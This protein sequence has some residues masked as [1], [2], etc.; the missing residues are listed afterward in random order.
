MIAPMTLCDPSELGQRLRALPGAD[1]VLDA[2]A[3]ADG[4]VY[5]VGGTV[6]DLWRGRR[7]LDLDLVV[8]GD[9]SALAE[10]LDDGAGGTRVHDRFGTATLRGPGGVRYDLARA[11]RETYAR[12]GALP[13]VEPAGIRDDLARRDFSVNALALGLSGPQVGRLICAAHGFQDMVGQE[14]RVLHR[15]SF[16]D[17]PIRLLRL[18]RYGA[19]L[20]FAAERGTE[21]LARAAI[22]EGA[23]GT[24]SGARIGAELGLLADE[25][26]PIAG[27][28]ALRA[29]GLDAALHPGFG[30]EDPAAARRALELLGAEGDRGA[31]ALAAAAQTIDP[32]P[33]RA[34]LDDLGFPAARRDAVLGA[35]RGARALAGALSGARGASE[36]AAA[37]GGAPPEAVALAGGLGAAA[38]ARAWLERLRHVGLEIDGDDLLAAGIPRGRA[39]GAGLRAAL[40]AKLEGRAA[41]RAAQLA[42]A[43][44][45]ARAEG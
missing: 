41:G 24:V 26:D 36:I 45:A 16:R 15:G 32:A 43:L 4:D 10:R 42:E 44:R 23:L 28:L 39:V 19:R 33:L 1:R 20:G 29:L 40:A 37:V 30:L 13:D 31:V 22:R 21:R 11:R 25:P 3:G 2:L 8:V 12:P 35:A 7:P 5:V 14:L 6:R 38:P 34:W 17:D 9:V 18:A 27:L